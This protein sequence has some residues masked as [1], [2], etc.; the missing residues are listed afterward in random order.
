MGP[1]LPTLGIRSYY[2]RQSRHSLILAKSFENTIPLYCPQ[3]KRDARI[4]NLKSN[5]LVQQAI[6]FLTETARF[7]IEPKIPNNTERISTI[8]DEL[9]IFITLRSLLT[10]ITGMAGMISYRT[11]PFVQRAHILKWGSRTHDSTLLWPRGT[12][13]LIH[14]ANRHIRHPLGPSARQPIAANY[15]C[16]LLGGVVGVEKAAIY[17]P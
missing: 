14:R 4:G 10:S 12:S 15:Y 2:S 9:T 6:P 7:I 5:F 1:C 8:P 13:T 16:I 3:Y 11:I 17:I